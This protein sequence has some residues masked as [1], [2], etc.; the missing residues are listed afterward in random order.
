MKR[1]GCTWGELEQLAQDD[2]DDDGGGG[3]GGGDNGSGNG[4]GDDDDDDDDDER[5]DCNT[6][7]C[8]LIN[9]FI[10]NLNTDV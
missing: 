1:T 5:F 7:Y 4:G 8:A 10:T 9:K 3:G 6:K 2:D